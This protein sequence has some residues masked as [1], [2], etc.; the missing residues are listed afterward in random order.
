MDEYWIETRSGV[1][2]NLSDPLADDVY[3][4]DIAHGLS[5]LCRYVGQCREFY[6]VAE[7]S[8]LCAKM[9][10]NEGLPMSVQMACLLHD[11]AEAYMGDVSRPLKALLRERGNIELD[12]ME[13]RILSV[14]LEGLGLAG[15]CRFT[16]DVGR[17]DK[18]VLAA[19]VGCLM[20][21]RG[22]WLP[23]DWPQ[24]SLTCRVIGHPPECAEAL[25][26]ERYVDLTRKVGA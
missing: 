24:A 10:E 2:F 7:H 14:I 25:F 19:E 9:A 3:I 17:I 22:Q 6:S 15:R 26:L 8:V 12:L 21:R 16:A 23:N 13:S 20:E 5:L 11:A 18:A 1:Q 4:N